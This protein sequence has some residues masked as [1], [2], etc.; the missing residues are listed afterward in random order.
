MELIE[1]IILVIV[2]AVIGAFG[3]I[4]TDFDLGGFFTSAIIGFFGAFLGIWISRNYDVPLFLPITFAGK[5]Y[6]IIW[7]VIG[8]SILVI[9]IGGIRKMFR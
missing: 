4:L 5:T 8:S 1:I 6:P 7:C 9:G 2:S 3:Q